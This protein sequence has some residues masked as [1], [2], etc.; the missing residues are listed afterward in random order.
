MDGKLASGD[1]F[2]ACAGY[3]SAADNERG[4]GSGEA[5]LAP[6]APVHWKFDPFDPLS[7]F[8][9]VNRFH[10]VFVENAQVE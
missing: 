6:Q 5:R 7:I 1:L 3:R 4:C 8:K 2:R 10:Y 9:A